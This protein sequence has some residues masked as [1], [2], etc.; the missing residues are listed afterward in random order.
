MENTVLKDL[1]KSYQQD[2]PLTREDISQLRQ[3]LMNPE[4]AAQVDAWLMQQ[5]MAIHSETIA[6]DTDIN[7]L[8]SELQSRLSVV[9]PRANPIKSLIIRLPG[10]IRAA[11]CVLLIM[12]L[13]L[14]WRNWSRTSNRHQMAKT[15]QEVLPASEGAI[16]TLGDGSTIA[17]DQLRDSIIKDGNGNV[18]HAG[19][20]GLVYNES[21]AQSSAITFNT[22]TTPRGRLYHLVL[23]D[24]SAVWLNTA[25][26]LRYPSRFGNASREVEL[27]GE[28]YFEIAPDASRPFKVSVNK[29]T[30]VQVLGTRFNIKAYGEEEAIRATLLEGA[31]NVMSGQHQQRLAPGQQAQI[32]ASGGFIN[33]IPNADI[34]QAMAWRNG[35]FRFEQTNMRAVMQ[36]LSR[37]YNV[38]IV[39]EK[40]APLH[41]TFS[42]ELQRDLNL[43]QVLKGLSTMG[44]HYRIDNTTVVILP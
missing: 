6:E 27:Q 16:L 35:V 31:V 19:N 9:P 42:G 10:W 1:L 37:W 4:N 25:S 28:A 40:G 17:L 2:Q 24:G 15:Q 30:L 38:N 29:H 3:L 14:L 36:E 18:L 7:V 44:V 11:A 20:G 39:Y 43:S 33:F 23:E 41:K 34:D 26:S 8:F 5:F 21:T 12:G 32:P 22:L 13:S